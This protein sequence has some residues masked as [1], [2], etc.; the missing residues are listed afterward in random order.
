LSELLFIIHP[1]IKTC[2]LSPLMVYRC[3]LHKKSL[4]N[5]HNQCTDTNKRKNSFNL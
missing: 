5:P 2:N 4:Q 3:T 1:L